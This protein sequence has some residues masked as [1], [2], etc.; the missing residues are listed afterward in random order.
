ML[1]PVPDFDLTVTFGA[2]KPAHLLDAGD[3]QM[4]PGRARRHR[5][6]RRR[7]TGTR[8]AARRSRRST[9]R[10]TNISAGWSM[11]RRQDAGRDRAG[12]DGGGAGRRGLCPGQHLAA[13]RR[14]CRPRS[15]RP[16]RAEVNDERIGCILVGPGLGDIPQVLT[17]ALTSQ[18][19]EGDR[20][21]RASA[22]SAS[23]SGSRARTPS[24]PRTRASSRGCSAS[25]RAARPSGRSRRRGE[26]RGRRLQGPGHAGRRARRPPRLRAAGAGLAGER[27]DRRRA[28]RDHRGAA[29][30]GAWRRSKRPAPAS[31][32]TAAPPRSPGRR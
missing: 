24:S 10:A 32:C 27:R 9:R 23:P 17:L 22:W 14:A 16:T 4:R 20:R 6:R 18:R 2:L 8:S 26:R 28:R 5:H 7:A 3:A 31:G 12:G 29:G 15:S 13:D 19:A 25:S 1:S 21:R 11:P 30:A